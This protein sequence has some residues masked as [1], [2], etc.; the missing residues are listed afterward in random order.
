M[1]LVNMGLRV[2]FVVGTCLFS[3]G[4]QFWDIL[5][6]KNTKIKF[7]KSLALILFNIKSVKTTGARPNFVCNEACERW[8]SD[9]SAQKSSGETF[10]CY[11]NATLGCIDAVY[12]IADSVLAA[13][14]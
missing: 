4:S 7:F 6:S 10:C 12:A 13:L 8:G 2:S 14:A 5:Y 9:F 3:L 1:A 11:G